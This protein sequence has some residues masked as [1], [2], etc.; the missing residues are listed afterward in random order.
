MFTLLVAVDVLA[1]SI[2]YLVSGPAAR[3]LTILMMAEGLDG[4]CCRYIQR[5]L[6]SA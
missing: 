1:G 5:K 3:E 2:S 4:V 6:I